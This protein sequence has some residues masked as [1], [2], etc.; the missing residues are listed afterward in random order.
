MCA[1]YT[2]YTEDE[3]IEMR[4]IIDELNRRFFHLDIKDE[5]RPTDTAPIVTPNGVQPMKWGFQGFQKGMPII[6]A[7]S[8]TVIEKPLFRAAFGEHRCLVPALWYYEYQAVPGQKR[9][10]K[11]GFR[12]PNDPVLYMAGI[13]RMYTLDGVDTPHFTVL[14]TEPNDSV[15]PFHDRMPLV[16]P[17]NAHDA[18]LSNT[19][20]ARQL[21]TLRP[22]EMEHRLVG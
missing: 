21:L 12:V 22:A 9:K 6:N 3:V 8:E 10:Q 19:T 13:Y 4:E 5:V 15:R 20:S 14:T 16:L 18:W 1:R 11:I 7:R 17:R 2:V